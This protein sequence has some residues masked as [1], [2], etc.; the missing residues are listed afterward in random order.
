M[1]R[2]RKP[3]DSTTLAIQRLL[4]P[5]ETYQDREDRRR[6]NPLIILVDI[7]LFGLLIF[8]RLASIAFHPSLSRQSLRASFPRNLHVSTSEPV[9]DSKKDALHGLPDDDKF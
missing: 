3:R 9:L 4:T 1:K 8:W 6:N 7:L 2:V 5:T